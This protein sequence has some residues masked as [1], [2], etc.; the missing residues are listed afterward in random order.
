M[1]DRYTDFITKFKQGI[2][3]KIAKE[4]NIEKYMTSGLREDFSK[5]MKDQ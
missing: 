3:N 1:N 4:L 2:W 5:Y